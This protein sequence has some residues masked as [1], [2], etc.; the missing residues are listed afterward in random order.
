MM[1]ETMTGEVAVVELAPEEAFYRRSLQALRSPKPAPMTG[2]L[3]IALFFFFVAGQFNDLKSVSGVMVIVAAVLFHE[4]GHAAGMRLFG[5]RDVRM[6]FIP[7]FGAAV[8]GRPRG[9]VAWKEAMV[10]L[11][12][13]LPGILAGIVGIILIR[14]QPTA[15]AVSVV[16]ALL[17]LNVFNLLPLGFLDGG[18]FLGRVL[19]SRHRLLEIG[20]LAAGSLVLGLLAISAS[21]YIL[22]FFAVLG[23]LILPLRW[24]VLKAAAALRRQSHALVPDPDRL[25]DTDG[26]A[27]FAAARSVLRPPASG[28]PETVAGTMEAIL[29][30]AKPAPGLLASL[31]LLALYGLGLLAGTVAVIVLASETASANWRPFAQPD[32]HG[33]FPSAPTALPPTPAPG[34]GISHTWRCAVEGV[35]RFTVT[36][37]EGASGAAE[38]WMQ[39]TAERLAENTGGRVVGSG[40]VDQAGL[41][42]REYELAAGSRIVRARLFTAGPRRYEVITSAPTWGPNQQH[43]L[44][45]FALGPAEPAPPAPP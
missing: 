7:F 26:R 37:T 10:S 8:S 25:A 41:A 40:P 21:L 32:W 34:G 45:S 33:E 3:F 43:F 39:E 35:E 28:K 24:R 20:F 15:L 23:L 19:F 27:V 22:G 13:P 31:G 2:L 12:G 11:L 9:V 16:Q 1:S 30:A 36:A 14:A 44:D 17:L 6:F 5:F 42:G 4:A 38:A 18:R 29:D